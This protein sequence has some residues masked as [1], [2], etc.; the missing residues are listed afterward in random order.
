MLCDDN[1]ICV[2]KEYV[3]QFISDVFLELAP[4]M[5][6]TI[7]KE[8]K[9]LPDLIA[10]RPK[11]AYERISR[12]LGGESVIKFFDKVVVT[13]I[14]IKTGRPLPGDKVF[15]ALKEGDLRTFLYAV[16]AYSL[17]YYP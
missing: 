12:V 7:K 1:D 4:G 2:S 9:V 8:L 17:A 6:F 14:F 5:Y 13:H 3:R 15:Y 16:R 11:E 10:D